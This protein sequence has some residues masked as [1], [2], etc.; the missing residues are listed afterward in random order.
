MVSLLYF[1]TRNPVLN[2]SAC[3]F[4]MYRIRSADKGKPLLVSSLII[5]EYSDVSH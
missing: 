3:S 5:E 2:R 4:T 1:S